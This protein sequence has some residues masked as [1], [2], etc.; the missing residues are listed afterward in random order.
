MQNTAL[1][2]L[3]PELFW[4]C[5]FEKID[6]QN[7]YRFVIE[8]V[9]DRGTLEE[10]FE[11]KRYYGIERIKE[12]VLKARQLN[13]LNLNF[14]SLYFNLPLSQFRCYTIRQSHQG[15]WTP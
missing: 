2:K 4:D 6:Y 9:L 15:L 10:W 3:R 11:I 12:A 13:K 5:E 1:P 14:C 7:N 8:R